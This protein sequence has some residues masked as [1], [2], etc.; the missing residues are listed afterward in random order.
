M[1]TLNRTQWPVILRNLLKQSSYQ[2]HNIH[3]TVPSDGRVEIGPQVW[4]EGSKDSWFLLAQNG[5]Y[6]GPVKSGTFLIAPERVL[7]CGGIFCGKQATWHLYMLPQTAEFL[8]L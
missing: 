3:L 8:G 4:D 7:V 5:S 6:L 2:K 1:R